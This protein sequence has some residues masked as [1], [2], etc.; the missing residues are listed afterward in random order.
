MQDDVAEFVAWLENPSHSA[1]APEP[2]VNADS[3]QARV[4]AARPKPTQ[5]DV[6]RCTENYDPE[7]SWQHDTAS[8]AQLGYL[9]SILRRKGLFLA[10]GDAAYYDARSGQPHDRPAD[11]AGRQDPMMDAPGGTVSNRAPGDP[12]TTACVACAGLISQLGS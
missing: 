5:V 11:R 9:R 2:V 3:F 10:G 1:P 12:G 6:D 4:P 7:W 8:E